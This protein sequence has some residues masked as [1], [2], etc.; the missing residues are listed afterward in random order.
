VSWTVPAAIE[1]ALW[2]AG[3]RR[4]PTEVV[5][6]PGLTAAVVDRSRRYT[7]ERERL[8]QPSSVLGDLAARALFFSVVD[9]ARM[10]VPLG[11]LAGRGL[12]PRSSPVRVLD[13]G[14]GCGAMTLGA[15]TFLADVGVDAVTVD[16]VD[17]DR[18]ALAIAADAIELLA[19]VLD[20][21]CDVRVRTGDVAEARVSGT[22]DLIVL[23]TVLNELPSAD[24]RLALVTR[25][26]AM[27]D[28]GGA[29][30]AIEPALR[31]TT[32]DLHVLR[33]GILAAGAAHVLAP[34]TRRGAPCPMLADERDW[35]HE[36]RPLILPARTARLAHATG[37]RDG[38]MKFSY[39]V[40]RAGDERLVDVPDG[41]R[42]VRVVSQAMPSKGKHEI[43]VC[44]D[45]GRVRLRLLAR[46]RTA[47]N[48]VVERARRGDVL[49]VPEAVAQ[50]GEVGAGDAVE[51]VEPAELPERPG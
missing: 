36:E 22:F 9:A 23:G 30:I 34:C 43:Y 28:P 41:L 15:L 44:G 46:A 33:D 31:S 1:E 42:A 35:C 21:R 8:S 25:L 39:L 14:A 20:M 10:H 16:L 51:R 50:G 27:L 18:A 32:R 11:E 29:L 5:G 26:L 6:G 3:R 7:S 48:R 12:L 49:I 40:L 13:V 38:A 19:G 24:G 4:L 2:D 37:L 17:H 45:D 47:E